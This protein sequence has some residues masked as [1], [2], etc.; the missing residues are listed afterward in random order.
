MLKILQSPKPKIT[1]VDI[2]IVDPIWDH[3]SSMSH[4]Y[5]TYVLTGLS[6]T[7]ESRPM[8]RVTLSVLAFVL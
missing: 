6:I 7:E 5:T 8:T 3:V 2:G 1:S 4:C